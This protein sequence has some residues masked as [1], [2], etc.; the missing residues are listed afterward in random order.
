[1]EKHHFIKK[2]NRLIFRQTCRFEFQTWKKSNF[3]ILPKLSI[4]W[5]SKF[6]L[7]GY[8]T[9]SWPSKMRFCEN[10]AMQAKVGGHAGPPLLLRPS[11]GLRSGN[12][13]PA[14]PPTFA[15]SAQ[16]SQNSILLGKKSNL[17]A[18][19]NLSANGNPYPH[20]F[21]DSICDS[22]IWR[23]Q[24]LSLQIGDC[25]FRNLVLFGYV[26]LSDF[27]KFDIAAKDR[28]YIDIREK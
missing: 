27:S 17:S 26:L 23:W 1:M 10:R 11:S 21:G 16:F 15:R 18:K 20:K 19:A 7:A 8:I 25:K 6:V 28:T 14:C 24:I 22:Y 12:G 4:N 9:F 5:L 13:D 3:K 2:L